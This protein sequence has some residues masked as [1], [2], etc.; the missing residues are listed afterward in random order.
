MPEFIK[1]LCNI[2]T[3]KCRGLGLI[4]DNY[5]FNE[6]IDRTFINDLN[7][8]TMSNLESHNDDLLS[9]RNN[10]IDDFRNSFVIENSNSA[11]EESSKRSK[12]IKSKLEE[13]RIRLGQK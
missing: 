4:D 10:K 9:S 11:T 1:E 12:N 3:E 6:K 2:L 7:T 13:L 8:L 5:E